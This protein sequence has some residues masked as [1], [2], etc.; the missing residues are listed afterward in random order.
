MGVARGIETG[1]N[2]RRSN[3]C[4]SMPYQGEDELHVQLAETVLQTRHQ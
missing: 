3:T 1:V 4:G 2:W